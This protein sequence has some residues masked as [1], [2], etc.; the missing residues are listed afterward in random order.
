MDIVILEQGAYSVAALGGRKGGCPT[1]DFLASQAQGGNKAAD[2]FRSLFEQYAREG[3]NGITAEQFHEADTSEGIWRFA[4]GKLRVYCFKD[5]DE[6]SLVLLTH[7][8]LKASQKT[9]KG[10]IQRAVG[11]RDKYLADKEAGNIHEQ[12]IDE[13]DG[14]QPK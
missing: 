2:G 5:P 10:D 12:V 1:I 11:L 13:I 4:K 7:G 14:N 6:K 9:R 8:A 3:R